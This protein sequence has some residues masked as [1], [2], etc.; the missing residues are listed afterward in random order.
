MSANTLSSLERAKNWF[1]WMEQDV[2]RYRNSYR[3]TQQHRPRKDNGK[4]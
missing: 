2:Y 1:I 3:H 4:E